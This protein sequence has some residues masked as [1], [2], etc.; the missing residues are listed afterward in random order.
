MGCQTSLIKKQPK[1]HLAVYVI[2]PRVHISCPLLLA[3]P[4][5][6]PNKWSLQEVYEHCIYQIFNLE[7]L[8]HGRTKVVEQVQWSLR[9][10][11]DATKHNALNIIS[12]GT[13]KG[14]I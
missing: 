1:R 13:C 14:C 4:A 12:A 5:A 2:C 7:R 11:T 3:Q 10:A 6:S 8:A 9:V